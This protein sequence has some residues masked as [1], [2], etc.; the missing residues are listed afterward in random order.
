MATEFRIQGHFFIVTDVATR[1]QLLRRPLDTIM[2]N[3]DR[4]DIFWFS[5]NA[6]PINS[7]GIENLNIL[8]TTQDS[9]RS[10]VFVD[11]TPPVVQQ[12][13]F[14][15]VDI[16]DGGGGTPWADADEL[17]NWLCDNLGHIC[18]AGGG[19]TDNPFGIEGFFLDAEGNFGTGG[20]WADE[21]FIGNFPNLLFADNSDER[22]VYMFYTME[23]I[24][25][26]SVNPQAA[27]IVS[28]T[29]APIITTSD[30]IE[31]QLEIRYREVGESLTGAA[32][33]IITKSQILTTIAANTR[34]DNLV[35][36]LDR[37]LISDQDVVHL[38]LRRLGTD[39]ADNYNGDIG[40]GQSGMLA[41]AYSHNP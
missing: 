29:N 15:F 13:S 18:C 5:N 26:D 22:A 28:S 34:Q 30:N 33:E 31:W 19:G 4:N 41:E 21:G 36:D 35:F 9:P 23:R 7:Y 17:D 3:R 1:D 2:H 6:F 20:G 39:V 14:D 40:I 8:G 16:V 38:M 11:Q 10:Q 24:K 32:D 37:T 12:T 25:L 27:F